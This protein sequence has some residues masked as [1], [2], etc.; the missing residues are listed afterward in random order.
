MV[1]GL[2][3]PWGCRPGSLGGTCCVGLR[4]GFEFKSEAVKREQ[5][6]LAGIVEEPF[7]AW[8]EDVAAEES[9]RLGQFGVLLLELAVVG[10]GR[11]E[12]AFEFGDAALRVLGSLLRL[13][14]LPLCLLGLPP[15][16][17]IAAK[18]VVEQPLALLRIIREVGH[19]AH[20][21]NERQI[22]M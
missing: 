15:Q 9:E 21:W 11:R 16:L 1:E 17:V 18:Q 2:P 4:G 14:G 8:S 12:H 6:P 10:R 3:P 5:V 20:A 22:L 7:A 19:D 13:F